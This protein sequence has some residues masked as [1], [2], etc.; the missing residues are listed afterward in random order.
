MQVT[1]IIPAFNAA[2]W[3]EE[4][5]QSVAA[6][7]S[8]GVETIVVDDGS[9][10]NTAEIVKSR[11][12][13]VTLERQPNRGCSVA[14][15][16][17][18]ELANG[19]Y[20]KYLDADDLLVPGVLQR[21]LKLAQT[22]NADVVYG[23]WQKLA[24]DSTGEWTPGE[25]VERRIEDVSHDYELAF[26]TNMWCTTGAYLWKRSFLTEKHPGWHRNLPVIQ[27]ARFA[28]DAAMAHARFV[29]DAH[30][31]ALYRVHGT[32][33]VSTRSRLA[34][35]LDCFNNAKEIYLLWKGRGVLNSERQQ[36]LLD[37][38]ENFALWTFALDRQLSVEIFHFARKITPQWHPR[39]SVSRRI[40]SRCLGNYFTAW[41][42][43]MTHRE[44]SKASQPLIT[45]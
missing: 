20:V 33:S 24:R 9:C 6:E 39:L 42:Y 23:D 14:R 18:T 26:F 37:L 30:I 38:C 45:R 5:L 8:D 41:L 1:V 3:I 36:A 7:R 12:P 13:W 29:H 10:D 35:N 19:T 22:T 2:H 15:A 21:Q 28:L 40:L 4:T 31:S 44:S 34:F 27:D 32:C 43:M 16:R 17:G 11:F 25:K